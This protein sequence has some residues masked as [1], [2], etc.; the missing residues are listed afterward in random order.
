M[1]NT[2]N[3]NGNHAE[4]GPIH[5]ANPYVDALSGEKPPEIVDYEMKTYPYAN[6]VPSISRVYSL[7]EEGEAPEGYQPRLSLWLRAVSILILAGMLL[8]VVLGVASHFY[9]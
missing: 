2:P 7:G 8:A 5:T 9:G 6:V 3:M 1:K 4:H